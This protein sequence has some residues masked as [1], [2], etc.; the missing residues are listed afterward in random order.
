MFLFDL[1][2]GF[3]E[4]GRAWLNW[5]GRFTFHFLAV[6]LGKAVEM[7]PAYALICAAVPCLAGVAVWGMARLAGPTISRWDALFLGAL[8]WLM[9]LACHQ[10][11]P[12]FYLQTDTLTMGLQCTL[13]LCFTWLLCR[14][15]QDAV[16]HRC[17]DAVLRRTCLWATATGMAAVGVYEHSALVVNATTVTTLCLTCLEGK[18]ERRQ[19]LRMLLQRRKKILLH[20]WL[21]C[22]GALLFSFLSP[23]NF[24]RQA[25]RNVSAE[26]Q[27]QQLGTAWN[28][29]LDTAF[30]LFQGPWL[31]LLILF[32]M[33]LHMVSRQQ[34]APAHDYS[35]HPTINGLLII[36]PP[37][38]YL[39]IS[40]LL[41]VLHAGSDVTISE[42]PK[43][44]AGLSVYAALA[45][46]LSLWRLS[47]PLA[48]TLRKLPLSPVILAFIFVCCVSGNLPKIYTNM[49]EG[50][51]T[52]LAKKLEHRED[53]LYS[54]GK[55]AFG[56]K[57]PPRFGLAGE[58]YRPNVRRRT[59]DPALP[60]AVVP[61]ISD[62]YPVWFEA[63]PDKPEQWPN[64]W[65]AWLY[66]VGSLY[67]IDIPRLR[68]TLSWKRFSLYPAPALR[69]AGLSAAWLMKPSATP[70][71]GS[72][73]WLVLRFRSVIPEHIIFR[74]NA[75]TPQRHYRSHDWRQGDTCL[76]PFVPLSNT[77]CHKNCPFLLLSLD[78]RN[79]HSLSPGT[80]APYIDIRP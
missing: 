60:W 43:F 70:R 22:F 32:I 80:S 55:E 71:D 34:A 9:L 5:S 6:F 35:P 76:L 12:T 1:P 4:I 30:G 40:A 69:Q 15:W 68:D 41:T 49:M 27:R 8:G 48:S 19:E 57:A 51:L 24:H 47:L 42:S 13:T 11:L 28:E 33:L 29:W 17:S 7:R 63:L 16:D 72:N 56:P 50:Q 64:L 31:L 78:G 39:V 79:F 2:G 10:H 74:E 38:V 46:G 75:N 44:A 61:Q 37:L 21:F 58:I 67:A 66:G 25:V 62:V 26:V 36:I 45:C 20:I 65:A 73:L 54:L 53:W 77:D 14:V 23:G 18:L 59:I 52:A 3:Y